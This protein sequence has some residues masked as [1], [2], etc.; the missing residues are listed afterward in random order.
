MPETYPKTI[1]K[2]PTHIGPNNH[3]VLAWVAKKNQDGNYP[4][5]YVLAHNP[6]EVQPYVVW[7]AYTTDGGETWAACWGQYSYTYAEAREDF[8]VRLSG[9]D[10]ATEALT[11]PDTAPM[12]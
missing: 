1:H 8:T 4:G 12:L 9:S 2:L 10:I 3:T 11:E 6:D 5:G 7:T